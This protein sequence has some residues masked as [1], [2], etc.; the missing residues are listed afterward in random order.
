MSPP[1]TPSVELSPASKLTH[2][3]ILID[4]G[5]L[6]K[7]IL[8]S[9]GVFIMMCLA[10]VFWWGIFTK[11]KCERYYSKEDQRDRYKIL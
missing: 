7:Y 2:N 3:S 10:Y 11:C 5:D 1:A 8:W 6:L 9:I 4:D